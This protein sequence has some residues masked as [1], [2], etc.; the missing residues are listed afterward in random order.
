MPGSILGFDIFLPAHRQ[1][2]SHLF[3]Y[4]FRLVVNRGD[5]LS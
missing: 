1:E 3:L 4:Y 5:A 2:S